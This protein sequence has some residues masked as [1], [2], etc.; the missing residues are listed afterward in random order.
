MTCAIISAGCA[1][2]TKRRPCFDSVSYG[3][4]LS[5][6]PLRSGGR[7]RQVERRFD[8]FLARLDHA[9]ATL[10]REPRARGDRGEG[11]DVA[12]RAPQRLVARQ[13]AAR[14]ARDAVGEPALA[15]GHG[16]RDADDRQTHCE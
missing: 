13:H 10:H 4:S 6:L 8:R 12:E 14:G 1:F 5:R 7:R 15:R 2:Q 3:T 16:G 11:H 9:E